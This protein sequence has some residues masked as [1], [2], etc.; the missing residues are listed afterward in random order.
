MYCSVMIQAFLNSTGRYSLLSLMH[1]IFEFPLNF[2]SFRD[3]GRSV[4][5]KRKAVA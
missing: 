1:V 4:K 5:W 3:I 2:Q